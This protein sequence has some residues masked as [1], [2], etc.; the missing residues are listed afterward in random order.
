MLTYK[1]DCL[2]PI[3]PTSIPLNIEPKSD[4]N[5]R[6]CRWSNTISA[7][8]K[9]WCGPRNCHEKRCFK[10]SKATQI[11]VLLNTKKKCCFGKKR[12]AQPFFL[13]QFEKIIRVKDRYQIFTLAG[14]VITLFFAKIGSL[15]KLWDGVVE[16][17]PAIPIFNGHWRIALYLKSWVFSQIWELWNLFKFNLL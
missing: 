14:G 10:S 13:F 8:V 15:R 16:T 6:S 11:C 7:V 1:L 12:D 3:S 17:Y 2:P 5:R 4:L 9:I